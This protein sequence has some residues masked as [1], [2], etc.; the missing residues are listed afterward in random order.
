MPAE[1]AQ[2]ATD[3]GRLER[4]LREIQT[5]LDQARA[6]L[7]RREQLALAGQILV[8]VGHE[9]REPLGVISNLLHCLRLACAEQERSPRT[10]VTISHYIDCIQD[11]VSEADRTITGLLDYARTQE[12]RRE[13]VD[14]NRIVEQQA[15]SL[16]L[17]DNIR[18]EKQ[19][20]PGLPAVQVDRL[21]LERV[22]RNLVVNAIES[23]KTEGGAVRLATFSLGR[24]IVLE[25]ADDGPGIAPEIADKIFEPMFSTRPAGMGLGLALC[26]QLVEAN[27]GSI[28]LRST[29]GRGAA[30][31][32]SLPPAA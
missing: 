3:I 17:P 26:R 22:L 10:A 16:R 7:E 20:A 2:S 4:R 29:P 9:L 1:A 23:I 28:A 6:E 18:L 32:I 12:V 8:G 30:F 5:A 31:Q 11:Q 14:L 13:A 19:L 27:G 15:H 24:A 25:V 21:H